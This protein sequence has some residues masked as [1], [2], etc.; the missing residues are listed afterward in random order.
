MS[1]RIKTT[2]VEVII[3][4]MAVISLNNGQAGEKKLSTIKNRIAEIDKQIKS[5]EKEKK[6]LRT[7]LSKL[8]N[9]KTYAWSILK[10]LS[11]QRAKLKTPLQVEAWKEK[12]VK[13]MIGGVIAGKCKVVMARKRSS[14]NGKYRIDGTLGST[15]IVIY[16]DDEK[17]IQLSPGQTIRF[18]G[19]I[20][21]FSPGKRSSIIIYFATLEE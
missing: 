3:M 5:L 17:T 2:L 15:K 11:R 7:E 20:G 14:K 16:T 1:V 9:K 6:L 13:P 10:T 8:Q 12:T 4:V 18:S 19:Q 21:Y